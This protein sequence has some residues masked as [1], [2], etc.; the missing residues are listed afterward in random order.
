MSFQLSKVHLIAA[1]NIPKSCYTTQ[2]FTKAFVSYSSCRA[3]DIRCHSNQIMLL[4]SLIVVAFAVV[5][6]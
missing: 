2:S 5:F 3:F 4:Q 1:Y 6:S